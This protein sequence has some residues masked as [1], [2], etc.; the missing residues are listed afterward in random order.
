[1]GCH[2]SPGP[3]VVA[4]VNGKEIPLSDLDRAYQ[5]VRISQGPSPQD[6]SPEQVSIMKLKILDTLI[7]EEILQ[8]RA[9][10]INVAAS[11]EDVNARLT[12]MKAP[13]TQEEFDKQL[14]E[15][16]ESLDDLKKE[17]RHDLTER[18]LLN[19]EI[20]SK[21]NITDAEIGAY[22]DAHKSEWNFIENQYHLAQIVVTSAPAQQTG[23][24]QNN[25]ASSDADAKK[26]IAT[27]H[28]KLENGEAFDAVAMQYSED[29]NTNASGGD[30]GLVP[31]SALHTDLDAYNEISKLKPGQFTDVLPIYDSPSPGH[32]II[33]YAIYK[34]IGH[35]PAGQRDLNDPRVQAS[36]RQGLR[37]NH[38]QVLKTAYFD[39]LRDD[40]KVHNYLADQILKEGAH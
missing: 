30:R 17:I 10:K 20:E 3:D 33:A 32:H 2:R 21:I 31:E 34:L 13:Y 7:E 11:D 27:L 15:R 4:T 8:Q 38:A 18:K 40:A 16:K 12:E 5:N 36:I 14:K 9:A 24:L 19:K 1:M 28:Q 23:N 35:E 37:D 22:Y 6:P 39:M 29:P 25:K 26:K